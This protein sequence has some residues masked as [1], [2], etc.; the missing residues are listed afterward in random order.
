MRRGHHHDDLTHPSHVGRNRV[1]QHAGGVGRFAT[2]H[3][4]AHTVEWRDFLAQQGAVS[5]AVGPAL[6]AGLLLR[7]VVTAHPRGSVLQGLLLHAGQAVK[8]GFE[9]GLGQFQG[10]HV[11]GL[12]TVKTLGVFQDGSVA[13]RFHI[14]QDVGHALLDGGIGVGRPMQALLK[15]GFKVGLGGGQAKR[16]GLHG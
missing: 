5:I 14:G 10:G 15:Q 2:W 4:N 11:G 6:A 3:V 8:R 12:Q 9:F 16:T 13:T 7:L 1:H